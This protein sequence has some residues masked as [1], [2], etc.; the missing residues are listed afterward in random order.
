MTTTAPHPTTGGPSPTTAFAAT[1]R[2]LL[3]GQLT[4][5]RVVGLLALG[6]VGILLAIVVRTGDEVFEN[7]ADVLAAY[8]L[9]V[10]APVCT[11]WI[12]SAMLGDLIEDRLLAYLWLKPIPR[13][14]LPAAAVAAT[15]TIMV[16]LVVV[17]ITIAAAISGFGDLVVGAVAGSLLAVAGY[18]GL[19]VALGTRFTKALWWGLLYVLVWEN[20]IA[21]IADGTARL[22]IRSYSVS[23][24]SSV[25]DVD[26]TIGDRSMAAS[27]LVP[28]A[29][30]AAGTALATLVLN[31]RDID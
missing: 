6:A 10:V 22:S 31:R 17:P 4:R 2:L 19:F 27:I 7:S 3:R 23:I 24:L 20:A 8:G 15:F 12:A 11:L 30:M 28:L 5:L 16:P 14:V 1:Y 13:W 9:A 21:L 26:L 29:V 25:A 18:S